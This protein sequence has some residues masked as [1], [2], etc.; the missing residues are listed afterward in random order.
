MNKQGTASFFIRIALGLFVGMI[1]Y[2]KVFVMGSL[3]HAEKF[4]IQGFKDSW[5]PEWL[6]WLL[7]YTIPYV[8]LLCGAMLIVGVFVYFNALI[9]GVLLLIVA[10]GHLLQDAFYNPVSHWLPRFTLM[11]AL[12]LLYDKKDKFSLENSIQ[13]FKSK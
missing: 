6:L 9:I 12:L 13:L 7:G 5:I 1:G 3:Q 10:Y 11:V 2:H 8:E 4:F